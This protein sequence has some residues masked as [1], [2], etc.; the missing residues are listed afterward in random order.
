ML[1]DLEETTLEEI[2]LEKITLENR[3]ADLNPDMLLRISEGLDL[4]LISDNEVLVQFGT[5]SYPSE[6]LRDTDLTGILGR[7]TSRLLQ[8]PVKL[9]DL[10]LGLRTEAQAE[11]RILISDLLQSG[12]LTDVQKSPVEQYLHYTFTGE[13]RLAER[14]VSLLGTGPIG[15]RLAYSLLQ[16]GIGRITLLDDRKADNLWYSFLPLGP[17]LSSPNGSPTHV[18]LQDRLLAAGYT[19]VESL[20]VQLD[21]VGVEAAVTRSDFI[22]LAL[23]QPDLRLAHLVNRFCIRDRKPWLLTTIDGNFGLVG[24]LFLPVHTACYN[25]YR[26]LADAAIPS[27]EMA[28]RYHQHFLQ[29]GARSFFPGLPA[30]AEIVAGYASLAIVHFLVRNSSFALG[31][32]L[33]MDFDRMLIDVEDVLKL[34]RCPVCGGEKSAF[35]APFS[36][37][38]VTLS[39]A[40]HTHS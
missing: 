7:L 6:L 38:I 37:E 39:S 33:T 30:Y 9:S 34:P 12:I 40:I 13:S 23:E 35:Q 21:T 31:R 15:V 2:T 20:D 27:P 1:I 32:V 25:D 22:I 18:I 28:R 14:S 19:G 3:G 16:H 17:N 29:R 10:L 26:T 8:G 24:P 11:A 4:I 5:R 36:A